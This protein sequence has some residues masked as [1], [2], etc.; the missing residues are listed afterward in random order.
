MVSRVS[1][2]SNRVVEHRGTWAP[3]LQITTDAEPWTV[4]EDLARLSDA[5]SL[6]RPAV[7]G[8]TLYVPGTRRPSDVVDD[9]LIFSPLFGQSLAVRDAEQELQRHP[10]VI[11]VVGHSLGGAVAAHLHN[12]YSLLDVGYG[13]PVFNTINRASPYD[14]VSTIPTIFGK[15]EFIANSQPWI[16]HGVG[17]YEV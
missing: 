5:Y 7:W 12:R 3:K 9:L 17:N 15:N 13:S 2:A 1:A 10:E 4:D 16:H 6:S 8:D 11:R 14:P